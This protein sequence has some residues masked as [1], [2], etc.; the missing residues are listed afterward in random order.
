[1]GMGARPSFIRLVGFMPGLAALLVV[2]GLGAGDLPRAAAAEEG[3]A[4]AIIYDTSG[5]MN[6]P[7]HN[8]NGQTTP[9]YVIAN[10]ALIAVARQIQAFATNTASGS[11]RKIEAGLWVFNG[12]GARE[13]VKFGPFEARAFEDFARNFSRP[14]GSTPLGNS[15]N[16]AA[17][18]VLT[19]PLTRKHVLIITDGVNTAGPTPAAVL[20]RLKQEASRQQAG[21]S[22]HFVAFD[23]DAKVFNSVKTLGATVVSAADEKQLNS[24]LEFILQKKIL[25][26]EEEPPK[27]P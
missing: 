26:E 10:G 3:V 24:Q 8:A 16:I 14:G 11:S 22:V 17:R 18:R 25:L 7:V 19:S 9:K 15:L 23:V 2:G 13:A 1:M 6:E 27:K 4:L 20:P 21:L 5:S 12:E